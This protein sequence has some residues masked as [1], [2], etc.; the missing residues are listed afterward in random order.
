MEPG[1]D[2]ID[3]AIEGRYGW[4]RF[5]REVT[6]IAVARLVS[7]VNVVTRRPVVRAR[8]GPSGVGQR[9]D[10]GHGRGAVGDVPAGRGDLGKPSTAGSERH[11]DHWVPF[12]PVDVGCR[13]RWR[14]PA[15]RR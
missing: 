8:S 9:G 12:V 10:S 1:I 14:A 6:A 3:D 13:R 4:E 15:R 5:V 11:R 7:D 2:D